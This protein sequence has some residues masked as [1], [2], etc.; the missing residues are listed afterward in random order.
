VQQI[1]DIAHDV[2]VFV[3][4]IIDTIINADL[5]TSELAAAHADVVVSSE[6]PSAHADV[7]VQNISSEEPSAH[8]DVVVQNISSE[9]ISAVNLVPPAVQPGT[10]LS[11]DLLF[12]GHQNYIVEEMLIAHHSDTDNGSEDHRQYRAAAP[13]TRRFFSGPLTHLHKKQQIV[14]RAGK[15]T[16]RGNIKYCDDEEEETMRRPGKRTIKKVCRLNM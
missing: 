11:E 10:H 9:D 1:L 5:G 13:A 7:V 14:R 8:A 16:I 3:Q 4:D 15:R 6:E 12:T 2:H